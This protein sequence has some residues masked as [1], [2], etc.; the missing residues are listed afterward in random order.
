M[1]LL[2]ITQKVDQNDQ[3]LGFF[4]DWIKKFSEKFEKVT[5]L[6]LEK[7]EFSLPKNV[8]I[9]SL[10][11]DHGVSKLRQLFTFYFLIF[12][13]RGEYDAVFVH[14]NP[15]WMVLGGPVWGVLRKKRFLWYTHKSV[16][17]KLRWAEKLS[18]VILTAS[19]ESFRLK[20]KK[21]IVTGH[22]IDTDLF[23]ADETKK[24]R[25]GKL[26]ILSVGRLAPVKNY[27]TLIDACEKLKNSW[28]KPFEVTIIGE[29]ALDQ[30]KDYYSN[31]KSKIASL[32][33]K[34]NF[35]FVGKINHKDL[36]AYYQ[37]HDVFVHMSKTGSVDK[38][39][40]EAMACGMHILSSNYSARAFLPPQF[41]F[42]EGDAEG[43]ALRLNQIAMGDISMKVDSSLI[44]YVKEHHNL[45]SLINKISE[46]IKS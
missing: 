21:V 32:G 33:L 29:P 34:E 28:N 17:A 14:M 10:G 15:I 12:T 3:L 26:K 40:L 37:D 7:G 13:L 4:I 43:L 11:K 23:V 8:K 35:N 41:L 2:I 25:D 9:V 30:D 5:V 18:D 36:P 39:L 20:S 19:L 1:R 24:I 31:M 16:T 46:I 44:I 22:G 6:C 27:E 42:T 38:T 45:N